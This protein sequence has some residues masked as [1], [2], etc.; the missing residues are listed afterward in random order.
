MRTIHWSCFHGSV[1][2]VFA[3]I[4]LSSSRGKIWDIGWS[5]CY[6]SSQL[7][8]MPDWI[9]LLSNIFDRKPCRGLNLLTLCV[10]LLTHLNLDIFWC[11]LKC[12]C[13]IPSF[14]QYQWSILVCHHDDDCSFPSR[15]GRPSLCS[16][17]CPDWPCIPC[18]CVSNPS[19]K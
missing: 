19:E 1:T 10:C 5:Y 16:L 14:C 13:L 6:P 12:P 15:H 8:V 7:Y 3:V 11:I 17:L 4:L 2:H 18:S 9:N